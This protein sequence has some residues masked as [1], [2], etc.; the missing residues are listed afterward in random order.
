MTKTKYKY[1]PGRG[2]GPGPSR[3]DRRSC[4]P[5]RTCAVWY[6]AGT[7]WPTVFETRSCL[8]SPSA[9]RCTSGAQTHT[10]RAHKLESCQQE[11]RWN[12][13]RLTI[14]QMCSLTRRV[15]SIRP[16]IASTSKCILYNI[17][18]LLVSINN[19]EG[20]VRRSLESWCHQPTSTFQRWGLRW[21]QVSLVSTCV[22]D[23]LPLSTNWFMLYR[24]ANLTVS[25][26]AVRIAIVQ[27][28]VVLCTHEWY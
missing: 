24:N 4:A 14:S 11:T 27:V 12:Q 16:P 7:V 9:S 25:V 23:R 8:Q 19:H 1:V 2:I 10:R 17:N 26:V 20:V 13:F 6:Q 3:R 5:G 28:L 18:W 22:S 15:T 21:S